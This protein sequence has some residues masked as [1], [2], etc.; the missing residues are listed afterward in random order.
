MTE[1]LCAHE[2]KIFTIWSFTENKLSTTEL[3]CDRL[4]MHIKNSRE[5]IKNIKHRDIANKPK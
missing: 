1:D 3:D 5:S 2:A 4:K